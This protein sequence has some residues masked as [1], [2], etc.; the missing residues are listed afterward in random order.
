MA[1]SRAYRYDFS[2]HLAIL[3]SKGVKT[4]ALISDG[5]NYN[6]QTFYNTK[7]LA[8]SSGM[9]VVFREFTN[10][11]GQFNDTTSE[12]VAAALKALQPQALI[13]M[14]APISPAGPAFAEVL[15]YMRAADFVPPAI[16]VSGA[17]DITIGTANLQSQDMLDYMWTI[18]TWSPRLRGSRS[19]RMTLFRSAHC[20]RNIVRIKQIC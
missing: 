20:S 14:A 18:H 2:A 16:I 9:S 15:D 10:A 3:R 12:Q 11:T 19:A 4:L 8:A 17:G 13:I 1:V 6:I 5:A 7:A